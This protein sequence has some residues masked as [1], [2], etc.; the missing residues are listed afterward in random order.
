MSLGEALVNAYFDANI[1]LLVSLA[2]WFA[3]RLGLG[4]AGLAPSQSLL[5]RLLRLAF[6]TA[7][8]SP[9]ATYLLSQTALLGATSPLSAVSLSDYVISQYIQGRLALDSSQLE[10]LLSA[11]RGLAGN[12]GFDSGHLSAAVTGLLAFGALVFGL[13]LLR[14]VARLRR[15]V[16]GC[17]SWRR[18]GSL[19]LLLSDDI[20]VPF[21][22][23]TLRRRVIV[24]PTAMLC[25]RDDLRF[26]IAHEGQHLRSGDVAWEIL[27]EGLKPLFF[28]NPAFHV[29]KSQDGRLRE[30]ACDRRVASR[31][32]VE[33]AAYCDF[34]LRISERCRRSRSPAPLATSAVPMAALGLP[35]FRRR[36]GL[37]L[38]QRIL[39][40]L[41]SR[42]AYDRAPVGRAACLALVAV[43][44]FVALGIRQPVAL[45]PQAL[46]FST[47]VNH[48]R[49]IENRS[50]PGYNLVMAY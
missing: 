37:M 3:T 35:I 25:S 33:A 36:A 7:L 43:V 19:H 47:I 28:W 13:G 46:Q 39:A 31:R 41:D 48:G 42:E 40:L 14:S 8:L 5:Q 6:L 30:L 38:R 24:V 50:D 12:F 27:L 26:A 22:A 2:L 9:L 44:L 10:S 17:H 11:R 32:G 34:L 21:A 23:R 15:A 20:A 29:W 49:F 18:I 45:S 4:A 1:L 16:I